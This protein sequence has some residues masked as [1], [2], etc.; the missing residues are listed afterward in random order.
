MLSA[1]VGIKRRTV[2]RIGIIYEHDSE[3]GGDACPGEMLGA[4]TTR[5][6][7]GDPLTRLPKGKCPP[8]PTSWPCADE[9]AG[10]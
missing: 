4:I 10:S 5:G 8:A 2:V 7:V 3:D 1:V 9:G 6:E